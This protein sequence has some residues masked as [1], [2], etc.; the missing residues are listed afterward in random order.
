MMNEDNP[1]PPGDF[2]SPFPD[3]EGGMHG[4]VAFPR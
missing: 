2:R 3:H 4:Q 1:E